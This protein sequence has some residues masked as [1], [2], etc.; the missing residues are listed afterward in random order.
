MKKSTKVV[1][2]ALIVNN[3]NQVLLQQRFDP[4]D[5]LAHMKWEFPGGGVEY[6]ESLEEALRREVKEESGL[7]IEIRQLIP[8][9]ESHIWGG[10][11]EKTHVLFFCFVAR[12]TGGILKPLVSEVHKA[13]WVDIKKAATYDLL[14][15]NK[16]FIELLPKY[17]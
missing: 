12:M 15:G 10:P 5:A 16:H 2:T 6:G 1:V 3:K 11:K 9:C 17:L 8:T 7:D 4:E 14:P 13:E